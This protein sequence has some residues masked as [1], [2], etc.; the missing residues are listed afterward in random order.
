MTSKLSWILFIPC[1][2]AAAFFKLAQYIMPDGSVFGLSGNI[3]DY[4]AL[5]CIGLIFLFALVMCIF[6]RRISP[7][8]RPHR[9]IPAGIIGLLIAVLFA[10][11]GADKVFITFSSGNYKVLDIVEFVLLFFS[12]IVFIVLGLTHSFNNRDTKRFALFNVMPAILCAVRLVQC[13]V[14]FTTVSVVTA[15][16]FKLFCYIFATLF[17]FN[18]A[19]TVS[20]TEAKHAVKSCFIYGFPAAAALLT[21]GCYAAYTGFNIDDI[22]AN[23][24]FVEMILMGL[25]ILAFIIELTAF[26]KDKDHV[27]IDDGSGEPKEDPGPGE[28]EN[29]VITG[30]D[31][32]DPTEEE[33]SSY[34]T[35]RDTE[36]YLYEAYDKPDDAEQEA[37]K[38]QANQSDPDGYITVESDPF[39]RGDS[40]KKRERGSYTDSLDE[41]DKLILEISEDYD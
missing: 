6:D 38:A 7:Y 31:D 24:G 32:A 4:I 17:F 12:A 34:L 18:Y 16:V 23:I 1:T 21:Y 3:L 33:V 30:L 37:Q 8:Y 28:D 41:I 40:E 26:A 20:L 27:V 35:S 22:F 25:Y 2:I 39:D 11:D 29:F 5:C 19:V 10:A 15:D 9:N 13:F 14:D 36:G